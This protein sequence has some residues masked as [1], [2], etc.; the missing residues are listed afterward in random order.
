MACPIP[1]VG[2]NGQWLGCITAQ[3]DVAYCQRCSSMVCRSVCPFCQSICHDCERCINDRIDRD[4]VWDVN[5]GWNKEVHI[6]WGSRSLHV[7]RQFWGWKGPD[8]YVT[9]GLYTPS[10]SAGDSTDMVQLLIGVYWTG[11]HLWNLANVTEP[12]MWGGDA[13][14]VKLFWP[15]VLSC[16]R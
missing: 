3:P 5:S 1:Y 15:L 7:K 11:A 8:Q 12:S 13:A 9:G 4:A 14:Y 16:L 2:H 6:R 10:D